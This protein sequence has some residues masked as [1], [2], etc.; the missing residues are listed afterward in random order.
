MCVACM[1]YALTD[2]EKDR[3]VY[4]GVARYNFN[5][6]ETV[7]S[8]TVVNKPYMMILEFSPW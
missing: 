5:E 7:S 2:L 6:F 3:L 1:A 8:K 4:R